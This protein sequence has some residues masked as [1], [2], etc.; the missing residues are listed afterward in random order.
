[1]RSAAACLQTPKLGDWPHL[2]SAFFNLEEGEFIFELE[3]ELELIKTHMAQKPV[4][5]IDGECALP[6]FGT[7]LKLEP[8]DPRRPFSC[9]CGVSYTEP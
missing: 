1:M 6:I 5:R 9:A 8:P 7:Y 3:L 2:I 4:L